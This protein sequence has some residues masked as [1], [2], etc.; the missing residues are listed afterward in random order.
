MGTSFLKYAFT[1]GEIAPSFW[2]RVDLPEWQGG[3]SVMRNMFVNIRGGATS[4]AGT[5]FVGKCRQDANSYPP[6]NIPFRVSFFENYMLE[7]GHEYMRPIFDGGYVLE[8]GFAITSANRANPCRLQVPGH[9]YVNGDWVYVDGVVGMTQLN[10]QTYVV[11][12][13]SAGVSFELYSPFGPPINSSSYTAYVSGGTVRRLYTLTTPY[14]AVDLPYLKF[15]QSADVMSLCLVNQQ[16]GTEYEQRDLTRNGATD[17][18][19]APPSI[20]SGITAPISVTVT[21][22]ATTTSSKTA[23]GYVVTAVDANGEES[24]ASP[25]GVGLDSIN[26]A[27]TFGTVTVS[28][29]AVAGSV[30]YNIYKATPDFTNQGNFAGQQFGYVATTQATQWRDDNKV[31]DFN[32]LPP[33]HLNPF[34]RGQVIAVNMTAVGASYT[35]STTVT[36]S[37]ATGSGFRGTPI[38]GPSLSGQRINLSTSM[39]F[40]VGDTVTQPQSNGFVASGRVQAASGFDID[41]TLNGTVKF[42]VSLSSV[43][44]NGVTSSS[45]LAVSDITI[46]G[47]GAIVGV[48]VDNPGHDYR[49]S[50][51]VTFTGAGSGAAANLTVG[52]LTGT[53]PSVPAYFQQR[54]VYAAALTDPDTY[55]MSQP[56]A[57]TNFDASVP[58]IDSDAI[59]GTPWAQ[60][61][62]GIQWMVPMPGGLVVM[63]GLGAWLV[64]GAAGSG[65][66]ITPASQGATPQEAYGI[67]A[68]LPPIRI[69]YDIIYAQALGNIVRDLE[70]NYW[71]NIYAGT[72]I[73]VYSNHLFVGYDIAQWGWA[74]NPFNVCW[75][76]RSDGKLLSLTY[77]K[78]QNRRTEPKI[79]G[80]GRHDTQGV[81]RSV[82][83]IPEAPVDA[84]YFII[85]RYVPGYGVWAYFQERMNNRQ[86]GDSV[87]QC[88]CVDAALELPQPTP[89]A[90]L[91]A[92]GT[93]GSVTFTADAAVFASGDVGKVIRMGGGRATITA[94]T[95]SLHVTATVSIPITK[96]VPNDPNNKPLPAAAGE[97]TMTAPVSTITGLGHL[98]GLAVTGV[99]DGFQIPSTTVSNGQI[100]LASPASAIIVGLPFTAQLQAL[101]VETGQET[102]QGKAMHV[103]SATARVASSG[104]F[105]VGQDQPVASMQPNQA[106]YDWSNMSQIENASTGVTGVA[107]ALFTGDRFISVDG[108]WNRD[109][110]T[111]NDKVV[112]ASEAARAYGMIALQQRKPF[113]LEVACIVPELNI[114]D[115]SG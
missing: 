115:Q 34:A 6:R 2:G 98:E 63:T 4:R 23:Y 86:W 93:S 35:A 41:V 54:R 53:Y 59:T 32:T 77:L 107:P 104:A 75:A 47:S 24:V 74:A 22:S 19:L 101:M 85:R 52:P 44:S 83:V 13:V 78:D 64:T 25:I 29:P 1:A 40:S 109:R 69:G 17:W 96:T 55:W 5:A 95:D 100:T 58:P 3:A 60:Q 10:G 82:A 45:V 12:G 9:N 108:A 37:S 36:I 21:P 15:T 51:T 50:D 76:V 70:Y 68:T 18:V 97:W 14:A 11:G 80:W 99:A 92:S 43:I 67:S 38:I 39:P 28:W 88:W 114:G 73:S 20:A 112:P 91:S 106:D 66:P 89:A 84:A 46:S 31:P 49:S 27:N 102:S 90:T 61:V 94:Y 65:S 110:V 42:S 81:F 105:E 8:D 48:V 79:S 56:G 87:E 72:D 113:P 57:Y 30:G 111:P 62:N 103:N 7:F 16:T 33:R 26:I 71:N